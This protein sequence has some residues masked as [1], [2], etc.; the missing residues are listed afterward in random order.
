MV[1]VDGAYSAHAMYL[2][3]ELSVLILLDLSL[4]SRLGKKSEFCTDRA[5]TLSQIVD[6]IRGRALTLIERKRVHHD[7]S[8]ERR[9]NISIPRGK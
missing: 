3:Q 1:G 8:K 7:G 5:N 9:G 2:R 4:L 6:L